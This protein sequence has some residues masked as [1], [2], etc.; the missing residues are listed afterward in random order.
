M[1]AWTARGEDNPFT[2]HL[3]AAQK[4]VVSRTAE[5]VT[6]PNSTLIT[7]EAAETVA[8][9]KADAELPFTI[10]GSGALVRSL[11]AAGLVDGYTL[12]I[13]PILLGS[14]TRLFAEGER[15][16]LDLRRSVTTTTGVVIADYA[17]RH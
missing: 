2:S 4:Y 14:G 7:G 15:A 6:W 9:L 16:D 5:P 11:H 1:T 12:L 3:L 13:H 17:V 8:R 10:I